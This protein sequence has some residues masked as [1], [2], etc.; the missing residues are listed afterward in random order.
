MGQLAYNEYRNISIS[1]SLFLFRHPFSFYIA[2]ISSW[3][4]NYRFDLNLSKKAYAERER[5]RERERN[6]L[7]KFSELTKKNCFMAA[8]YFD[9]FRNFDKFD[10]VYTKDEEDKRTRISISDLFNEMHCFSPHTFA[11][12]ILECKMLCITASRL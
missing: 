6:D 3:Y 10:Y 9:K 4:D 11:G 7:T 8:N 2:F 1:F 5:E 12:I